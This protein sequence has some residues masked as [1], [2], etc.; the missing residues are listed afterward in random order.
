ML[1]I[2]NKTKIPLRIDPHS[3]FWLLAPGFQKF[4]YLWI[5][6]YQV[7]VIF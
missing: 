4:K 2:Q 6:F 3:E 5:E 1:R 7:P